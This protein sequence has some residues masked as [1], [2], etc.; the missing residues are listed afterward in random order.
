M[1]LGVR[2]RIGY[3]NAAVIVGACQQMLGIARRDGHRR[4]V[5]P[6][7]IRV[8]AGKV[9]SRNHVYVLSWDLSPKAG[10][11]QHKASYRKKD[12]ICGGHRYS[13]LFPRRSWIGTRAVGEFDSEN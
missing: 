13:L 7:Q 1:S 8:A 5:L 4:L 2:L 11:E 10:A 3:V 9:R 6:L 12:T